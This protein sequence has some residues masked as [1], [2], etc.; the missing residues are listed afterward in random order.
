ML[1][2]EI[3]IFT[4]TLK[5]FCKKL[6]FLALA[7]ICAPAF[8]EPLIDNPPTPPHRPEVFHASPAF[9]ESVKKQ[10]VEDY[11]AKIL[12][13]DAAEKAANIEPA[14]GASEL[15]VE[16]T[17]SFDILNFVENLGLESE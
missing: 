12:A 17:N 8:A 3:L 7:L 1:L 14:A 5:A 2:Q 4:K 11:D 6:S 9:F 15:E 16:N 10:M 13:R